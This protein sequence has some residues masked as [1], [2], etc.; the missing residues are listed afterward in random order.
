MARVRY[1]GIVWELVTD[2]MKFNVYGSDH[3]GGYTNRMSSGECIY[4][5]S[6]RSK[7]EGRRQAEP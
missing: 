5:R 2:E 4:T 6:D 1:E 7:G 3:V